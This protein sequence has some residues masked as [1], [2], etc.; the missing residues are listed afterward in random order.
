[1]NDIAVRMV[2]SLALVF[3]A[4][5]AWAGDELAVTGAWARP[6]LGQTGASA[7]YFTI[8]NGS[9]VVDDL[10]SVEVPDAARAELHETTN[11]NGVVGMRSI[12]DMPLPPGAPVQFAPG[13]NH[14]M[15]MGL[16]HPLKAGDHLTATLHFRTHA[17]LT[18]DAIVSMTAPAK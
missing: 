2:V 3:A 16:A 12:A 11:T 1:L 13:G 7:L 5:A 15:L 9:S 10:S 8:T 4:S 17:P 14:V 6:S 18:I